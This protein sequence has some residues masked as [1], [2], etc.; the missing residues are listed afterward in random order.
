[1]ASYSARI[2]PMLCLLFCSLQSCSNTEPSEALGDSA[3]SHDISLS[4][5]IQIPEDIG[6]DSEPLD[7]APSSVDTLS[8]K[9]DSVVLPEPVDAWESEDTLPKEETPDT[10]EG[11]E[12]DISNEGPDASEASPDSEDSQTTPDPDFECS[13]LSDIFPI[14]LEEKQGLNN[15]AYKN[16]GDP[17]VREVFFY[18]P[19]DFDAS[20]KYP[21]VF[22]FH[23]TAGSPEAWN[24]QL[25]PWKGRPIIG[26]FPQ[27]A[28]KGGNQNAP[29]YSWNTG[30]GETGEN[31]V[32]FVRSLWAAIKDQPFIDHHKVF[33]T[34]NS[35]GSAFIANRLA[36][37]PCVD[38]LAGFA[39]GSSQMVVEA[40]IHESLPKRTVAIFHGEADTLIPIE[41]GMVA[42]AGLNFLSVEDTLKKWAEH[43]DCLGSPEEPVTTEDPAGVFTKIEYTQCETPL[44]LYRLLGQGHGLNFAW[45]GGKAKVLSDIFFEN[46]AP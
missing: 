21:V 3:P 11:Q 45:G 28:M 12:H 30:V 6:P 2:I 40:S 15:F 34:G 1:M 26:V 5:D 13:D 37:D 23:G 9:A 29:K 27:G 35:V 10:T 7:G 43:N 38:F 17:T 8:S 14:D 25:G 44:V 18:I 46:Q 24:S 16:N 42:F 22:G 41:G 4:E 36:I 39:L 19:P 32:D 20:K 31:D 33:A